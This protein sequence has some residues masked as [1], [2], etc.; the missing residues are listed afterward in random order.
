MIKPDQKV[1][2]VTGIEPSHLGERIKAPENDNTLLM[3][4]EA[5]VE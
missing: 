5:V 3:I 4:Q 1:V 2:S